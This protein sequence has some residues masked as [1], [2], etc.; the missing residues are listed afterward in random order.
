MRTMRTALIPLA[1]LLLAGSLPAMAQAKW[2]VTRTMHIGG[3]GGWDYLTVDPQ[4][5]QLICHA[6]HPYP[7]DRRRQRESCWATFP[8][9]SGR[10]APRS[11]LRL[12]A[13]SSPMAAA[14]APSSSSI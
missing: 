1:V 4:T 6:Q 14:T 2:D 9:R 8:G 12:D 7:G 3:E 5:H 13:D 11:F 10:M